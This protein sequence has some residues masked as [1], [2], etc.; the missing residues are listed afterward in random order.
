M[1]EPWDGVEAPVTMFARADKYERQLE[2]HGIPNQPELRLLYAVLTYQISRQFDAAMRE[3]HARLPTNKSFSK[4]RVY[5]QN[6]YTKQVK[7]NR[8]TAGSVGKG[9][10]NTVTK[11]KISDVEANAMILSEVANAVHE[12]N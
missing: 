11:E 4:F 12:Q 7:R 9:I 6:E 10:A 8:S 1:L 5:I 3:W 2:R